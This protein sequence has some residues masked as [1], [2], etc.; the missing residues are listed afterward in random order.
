MPTIRIDDEVF[1]VLQKRAQA[2]VDSPN[3]VLRRDYGLNGF[4]G[5]K[6][7]QDAPD[8]PSFPAG[9]GQ[10]VPDRRKVVGRILRGEKTP[11]EEYVIPILQAL[12]K[13]GGRGR[14]AD[15]VDHV[16][17]IMKG[18]LNEY[19]HKTLGAGEIRWRNTAE[20]CRSTMAN[21]MSPPLLNPSSDHGWWEI[22]QAG[23]DYLTSHKS[24]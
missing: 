10:S 17:Q 19:D 12:V 20:W 14:T 2:F 18:R 9:Q 1:A 4:S 23:R 7:I 24:R 8:A 11:E 6:V 5:S 15:I 22:T 21:K 3:D 16:G 13:A